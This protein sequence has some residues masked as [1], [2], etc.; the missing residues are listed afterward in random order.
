[1]VSSLSACVALRHFLLHDGSVSLLT[2]RASQAL[3]AELVAGVADGEVGVPP[4]EHPV[5][6][7]AGP[8]VS[9]HA[10][11]LALPL[12]LGGIQPNGLGTARVEG[13]VAHIA[14][15]V[16]SRVVADLNIKNNMVK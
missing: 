8:A 11:S 13:F 10:T 14:S 16:V 9:A 4:G 1:M 6:R 2:N 7:G 5:A 12:S 15:E 3:V